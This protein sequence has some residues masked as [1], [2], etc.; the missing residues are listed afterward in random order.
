MI[1]FEQAK[2]IPL[3]QLLIYR[4]SL[5]VL[6][7]KYEKDVLPLYGMATQF[8]RQTPQQIIARQKLDK[9]NGYLAIVYAAI[10]FS[11]FDSLDNIKEEE[12]KKTELLTEG[13]KTEK[14]KKT[15]VKKT[16]KKD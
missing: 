3:T 2:N 6:A 8:D 9:V 12:S 7:S 10:E 11:T 1:T 4:E 15:N 14:K 5:E 16:S 13:T